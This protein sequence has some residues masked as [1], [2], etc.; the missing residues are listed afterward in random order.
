MTA[1]AR[2]DIEEM[3]KAFG[4]Q[5]PV[6][7][8][9]IAEDG[10][11]ITALLFGMDALSHYEVEETPLIRRAKEQLDEYFAGKRK[12]FDLPLAPKGT[13]F[14][15]AVWNALLEIPY[16]E[17]RTYGQIAARIERP[18]A[19]RAVGQANHRNPISILIP[20]HRVIGTGGGLTGYGGGLSVKEKLLALE[21]GE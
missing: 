11:A 19:G 1:G 10:R 16:G 8:L 2:G 18:G 5:T 20:C 12:A 14:Q 3:E 15:Q 21:R 9:V 7:D 17:T 13:A 6:G 4:Y